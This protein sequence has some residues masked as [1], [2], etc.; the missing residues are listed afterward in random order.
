MGYTF[1]I[2]KQPRGKSLQEIAYEIERLKGLMGFK[3]FIGIERF[4]GS[5]W[6]LWNL[7]NNLFR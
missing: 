4:M 3:D 5:F 7:S 6:D 1:D 2:Q